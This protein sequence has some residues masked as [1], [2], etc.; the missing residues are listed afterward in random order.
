MQYFFKL[1][2]KA[3]PHAC[4]WILQLSMSV[5]LNETIYNEFFF[6]F[7]LSRLKNPYAIIS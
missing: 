2:F 3:S 6:Y 5:L 1:L 7:C 4:F